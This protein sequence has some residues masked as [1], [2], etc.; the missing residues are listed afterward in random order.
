M[1]VGWYNANSCVFG[2]SQAAHII[3]R[4]DLKG[5]GHIALGIPP[6]GD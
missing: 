3:D 4:F 2:D 1:Q 5:V 6:L